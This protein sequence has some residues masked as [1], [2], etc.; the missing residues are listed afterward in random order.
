V[1]WALRKAG[2]GPRCFRLG[3]RV[4]ARIADWNSWLD[5]MAEL[6][7]ATLADDGGGGKQ[8]TGN[9]FRHAMARTM[10]TYAHNNTPRS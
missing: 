3:R 1:L 8:G 4:Y 5:A 2:T 10:T 7:P 9:A 6:A